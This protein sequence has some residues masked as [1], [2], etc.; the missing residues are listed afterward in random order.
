MTTTEQE[1]LKALKDLEVA[2]AEMNAVPKPNLMTH[3]SRID[4]LAA[5]LPTDANGEL[6]HYLQKKSYVIT[7]AFIFI[8][9]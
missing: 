9:C 1:I 5:S 2:V 3:F 8:F 6:Q 7:E 4:S